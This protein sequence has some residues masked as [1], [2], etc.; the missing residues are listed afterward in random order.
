MSPRNFARL[1][2]DETGMTPAKYVEMVRID[3]AR[4]YLETSA[5]SIEIIAEKSGFYDAERM[6]R[7]FIR[8]LGVNP[9]NYRNRFNSSTSER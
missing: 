3:A 8:Q 4:H 2:L 9:K 1:F 7:S 5:L 6:R